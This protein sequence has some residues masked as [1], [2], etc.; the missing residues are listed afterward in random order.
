MR[1]QTTPTLSYAGLIITLMLVAWPAFAQSGVVK[2]STS[3]IC[4]APDSPWYG[5]TKNFQAY[6]SLQQC[7]SSGGRLPKGYQPQEQQPDSYERSAFGSWA[8]DD[9]N[10]R[11]TRHELLSSLSTGP[12]TTS[13]DGCK[14]LRGRWNDPYTGQ[15][16]YAAEDVDVDHIVPLKVAW[17]VGADKWTDAERR[18]FSNDAR[19]LMVV[20]KTVNRQKGD[21]NPLAWLPPNQAY[22]CAYILRYLQVLII[23]NLDARHIAA[24]RELQAATC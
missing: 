9:R 7:L 16:F 17:I 1:L 20:S 22:Q 8:D 4:H 3:G 5:R 21:K 14:V 15:I 10:C 24:I 2:K 11:N 23:Y 18:S 6:D 19:N 13:A 12:V